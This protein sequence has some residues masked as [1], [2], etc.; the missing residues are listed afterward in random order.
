MEMKLWAMA[1]SIPERKSHCLTAGKWYKVREI[2]HSGQY[3]GRCFTFVGDNSNPRTAS[4]YGCAHLDGGNWT[5]DEFETDPNT[6][7]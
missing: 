1:E 2:L 5:L 3:G 7:L 6:E 4:E